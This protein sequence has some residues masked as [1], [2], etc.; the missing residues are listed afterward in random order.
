MCIARCVVSV[1]HYE[2][3]PAVIRAGDFQAYA[4]WREEVRFLRSCCRAVNAAARKARR[5]RHDGDAKWRPWDGWVSLR[6]PRLGNETKRAGAKR[7]KNRRIYA[8]FSSVR[9]TARRNASS[10]CVRMLIFS[11]FCGVCFP[12]FA[13]YN[14]TFTLAFTANALF[15]AVCGDPVGDFG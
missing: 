3:S 13:S 7:R 11:A 5:I 15:S 14:P 2:K 1:G 12:F 6:Q 10:V 9:A 8:C 4:R